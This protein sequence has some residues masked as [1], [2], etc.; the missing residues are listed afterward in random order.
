MPDSPFVFLELDDKGRE[1]LFFDFDDF[2]EIR[3]L[4]VMERFIFGR[5]LTLGFA[6]SDERG[7]PLVTQRWV[8]HF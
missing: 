7:R 4:Q 6:V 5:I 2:V 8:H 1:V 3:S